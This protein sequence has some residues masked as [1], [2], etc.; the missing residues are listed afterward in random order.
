MAGWS[1]YRGELDQGGI[2]SWAKVPQPGEEKTWRDLLHDGCNVV[3]HGRAG[4]YGQV[5]PAR[6]SCFLDALC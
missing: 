1:A 6:I 3:G 5:C 4:E 2:L